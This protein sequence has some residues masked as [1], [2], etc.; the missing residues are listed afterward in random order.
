VLCCSFTATVKVLLR[1]AQG[2]EAAWEEEFLLTK[3]LK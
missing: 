3:E 1:F 2:A